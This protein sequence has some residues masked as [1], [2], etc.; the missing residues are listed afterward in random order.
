MDEPPRKR[1]DHEPPFW[2][3]EA[4]VY[5]I[6]ICAE[7]RK[8]NHLCL[9][10]ESKAVLEAI[11]TYHEKGRWYC[12]LAVLMP[13]HVHLL[14]SFRD[15]PSFATIV[16]DWKRFLATRH[17]IKWQENFFD[18]RLRNDENLGQKGEYVL[19]NPLRAGLVKQAQDWPYTWM[20]EKP[21]R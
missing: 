6:T 4:S 14:L 7:P 5:F 18:H 11:R 12:H 10:Q 8:K 21:P 3:N 16:G 19:Q 20:P 15:V 9:P 17:G 13:D 2:L 1:L